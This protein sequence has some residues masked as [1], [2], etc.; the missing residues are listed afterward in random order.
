MACLLLQVLLDMSCGSGLFSRRFV[1]SGRFSGVIAADFSDNMLRQAAQYF[2]EDRTLSPRCV[3]QC[4]PICDLLWPASC[5]YIHRERYLQVVW[6]VHPA[7]MPQMIDSAVHE[8][9]AHLNA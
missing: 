5:T 4:G 9:F 3:S 7:P 8:H 1:K 2:S 6:L